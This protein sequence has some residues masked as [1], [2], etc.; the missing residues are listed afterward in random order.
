M[1]G[2]ESFRSVEKWKG[3][4]DRDFE[5]VQL[6]QQ[7]KEKILSERRNLTGYLEKEAERAFQGTC[8]AQKRLSE[9][10]AEMDRKERKRRNADIALYET[11]RQL[12]S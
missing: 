8:A 3:K 11:N 1:R 7:E 12:E 10:Q 9:A 5:S 4:R 6:S 2:V